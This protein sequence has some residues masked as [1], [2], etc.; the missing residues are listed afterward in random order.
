MNS[1][2]QQEQ[3]K[4]LKFMDFI[5][6]GEVGRYFFRR[7]DPNRPKNINIRMMHGI[8]RIAIVIFLLGIIFIIIKR[9]FL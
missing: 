7:K 4:K 9:V 5:S 8:N 2:E 1:E 6:M 3:P